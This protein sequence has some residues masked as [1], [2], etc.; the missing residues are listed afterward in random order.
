MEEEKKE[1]QDVSEY[2]KNLCTLVGDIESQ[3]FV[4]VQEKHQ[5]LLKIKK[6]NDEQVQK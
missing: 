5:L 3:I 4:L 1:V 2:Y 6:L